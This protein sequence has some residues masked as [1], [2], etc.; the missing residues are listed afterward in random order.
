VAVEITAAM[1]PEDILAFYEAL[2]AD[3]AF[4]PG[5]PFL[6]DAR[7]VTEAPPA[8]PLAA[9]A[10]AAKRAAIFA[11]P[12]KSAALVSSAWMYGVVRQ[13]ATTAE[14]ALSCAGRFASARLV[15]AADADERELLP[16]AWR[17]Q[18]L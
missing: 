2:A 4:R 14:G 9:T 1:R 7:G 6:V 13:W 5:T 3:P 15:F 18:S 12:T 17:S 10:L 11:V 16:T 8:G